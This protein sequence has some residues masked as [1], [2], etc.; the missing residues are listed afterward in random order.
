M[1]GVRSSTW[2]AATA[3]GIIV[4]FPVASAEPMMMCES[5]FCFEPSAS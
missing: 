1:D 4:T 5:I 2:K 3:K